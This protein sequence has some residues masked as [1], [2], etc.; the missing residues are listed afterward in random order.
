MAQPMII[1]AKPKTTPASPLTFVNTWLD[2]PVLL[3][4]LF[5]LHAGLGLFLKSSTGRLDNFYAVSIIGIGAICALSKRIP[6]IYTGYAVAY[7]TGVEVL[8]R[9]TNSGIFWNSSKFIIIALCIIATITHRKDKRIPVSILFYFL[10]LIPGVMYSTLESDRTRDLIS[11]YMSTPAALLCV[12]IFFNNLSISRAELQRMFLSLALPCMGIAAIVFRNVETLNIIWGQDSNNRVSGFGA[13]QVSTA[14]GLGIFALVVVALYLNKKPFERLIFVGLALILLLAA[15]YTFSRGGI[16]NTGLAVFVLIAHSLFSKGDRLQ[17]LAVIIVG[18][19]LVVVIIPRLDSD[20]GNQ[21][22]TRYTDLNTSGRT[23][24]VQEDIKLFLD[25][26]FT[27][28]GLGL[29][30][31][32][33]PRF[34]GFQVAPHTEYTRMLAEHGILGLIAIFALLSGGLQAYRKQKTNQARS[35]VA[36]SI[37]WAAF[38]MTHAA[39]R[40]V[41][42]AFLLGFVFANLSTEEEISALNSKN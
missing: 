11:D 39:M 25:Y 26:P 4:V 18:I 7:I 42:P 22:E 9:M 36:S 35:I 1:T 40:T 32:E 29:S 15:F 21:L 23:E 41:A 31:Q 28:V 5:A 17:T 10:C 2:N 3:L 12:S 16:F 33:R 24:I 20:T 8:W 13:N 6:L 14:L 27:G 37:V 38:Y 30:A 34:N 19:V